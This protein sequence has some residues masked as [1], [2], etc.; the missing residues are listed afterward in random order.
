M[1]RRNSRPL[2]AAVSTWFLALSSPGVV[3]LLFLLLLPGALS[4]QMTTDL[5]A[6]TVPP[7]NNPAVVNGI[8]T[9]FNDATKVAT[10]L[11]SRLLQ[12]D[13]ST[14]RIV[15]ADAD[16]FD[17]TLPQIVPGAH[18]TAVVAA[19]DAAI[20]V[21]PPPPLMALQAVVRP[22]GVA[23]L[24]GEIESVGTDSFGLLHRTVVVDSHT[25][26]S[27][28]NGASPVHGLPD[29]KAGMRVEV[30]VAA[31]GD[32]LTATKVVA[33]GKPVVSDYFSF[34]GVVK[35]TGTDAWTIGDLTVGV[36]VDTQIVGDPKA[37]DT[38]DVLAKVF[39]PPNPAM[40]M[41]SRI[42][43]V[44]IVKVVA[45]PAP[46]PGR[47]MSFAGP[48]QKMPP[49]GTIGL[50]QIA[51]RPVTVNGL[52]EIK[53]NPVVGSQVVVTGYAMSFA[54]AVRSDESTFAMRPPSAIPFMAVSITTRP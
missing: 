7:V 45:T 31:D 54:A 4:A 37:G 39:N 12:V 17:T 21:F 16:P 19:P 50:W 5:Q 24:Q 52:T 35:G 13:L 32:L 9:T 28:E 8:V 27:G 36:T 43:A 10:L 6:P 47:S 44:S 20:T 34:R 3:A 30:W 1:S 42:V 25:V 14:A 38:V 15:L 29:L 26:F 23:F 2:R 18:L 51:G 46:A 48:V 22:P 11:G 33:H 49:S 41:P 53:G 40:G